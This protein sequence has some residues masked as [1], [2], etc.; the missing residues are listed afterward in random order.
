[1]SARLIQGY[2]AAIE[3]LR[4]EVER[5]GPGDEVVLNVYL[6]EGG[7]SSEQVL[8]D[9][10]AAARRGARVS[11]SVDGTAAST[12]SRVV[13]RTTSLVPEALALAREVEGF[14]AVRRREPDHSKYALFLRAGAP[15]SALWGGI[16]IGDRFRPW[17]DFMVCL[18]GED[19]KAL[20]RKVAGEGPPLVYPP[21]PE[22][23]RFVA[24]LPSRGCF[25]IRPAFRAIATDPGLR[26]LRVAMA[27]IDR[28][29][30]AIL[31]LALARGARVDLLVPA[32][33]N[34]YQNANMRTVARLL[35]T[36]RLRIHALP[37][38]LHAKALLAYDRSGV[39]LAF[40]G[41]A[42]LK[43]NSFRMFKEVN[44]FVTE[45]TFL[46]ALE[47][48]FAGLFAEAERL[49]HAPP[50]SRAAAL[51]EERLG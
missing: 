37:H 48:A 3:A 2:D 17:R 45:A 10:V 38:M 49:E 28:V 26:R 51:I 5:T 29:G 14:R 9:L 25:E 23:V 50:Y 41:S 32:R 4:G 15:P 34:V 39:R 40:L 1:M 22:S 31:R 6:L 8:A 46:G 30:A 35:G 33:A 44:A 7:R 18:E 27:Y 42:N 36:P 12:L 21:P 47:E 16:N 19:A 43:R 11:L 13:E 20:A 24:N